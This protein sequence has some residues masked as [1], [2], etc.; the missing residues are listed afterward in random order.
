MIKWADYGISHIDMDKD[1]KHIKTVRIHVHP[2]PEYVD[3]KHYDLSRD[4]VIKRWDE[5]YSIVT[6]RQI[7]STWING[8]EVHVIDTRT[9]RFI[10]TDG[11]QT[12]TDNLE[13]LPP[14]PN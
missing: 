2:K 1:N 8:D 5:N 13:N 7:G 11:N 6:I 10:R 3:I 14:I 12:T 4:F 9:G